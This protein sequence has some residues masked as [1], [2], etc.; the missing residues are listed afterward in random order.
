MSF[1]GGDL[2]CF[3]L[4]K[5]AQISVKKLQTHIAETHNHVQQKSKTSGFLILGSGFGFDDAALYDKAGTSVTHR[6]C[7]GWDTYG[8][9]VTHKF[10]ESPL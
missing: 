8:G 9:F 7:T 10:G 6:Q 1:L 5:D 3:V 4:A 2:G